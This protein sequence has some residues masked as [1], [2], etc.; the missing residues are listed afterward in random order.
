MTFVNYGCKKFHNFDIFGQCYKDLTIVIHDC[1]RYMHVSLHTA[2]FMIVCSVTIVNY[3]R[4]MFFKIDTKWKC[5]ELSLC[6]LDKQVTNKVL[7]D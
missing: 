2:A 6:A 7:L 4:K 5:Y 1:S 3:A